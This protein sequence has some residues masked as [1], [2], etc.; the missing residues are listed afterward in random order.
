MRDIEAESRTK[1]RRHDFRT[2]E[3]V[4]CQ[5]PA[6]RRDRGSTV[7]K[8][9]AKKEM[10]RSVGNPVRLEAEGRHSPALLGRENGQ[11]AFQLV[12]DGLR[13][14]HPNMRLGG[15]NGGA[16]HESAHSQWSA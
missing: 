11:A 4:V 14:N 2:L 15:R 3:S 5:L 8:R 12:G 10:S 1:M 9:I 13:I 6:A 16:I 7:S